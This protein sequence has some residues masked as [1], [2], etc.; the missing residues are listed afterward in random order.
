MQLN[1]DFFVWLIN[2]FGAPGELYGRNFS[3]LAPSEQNNTSSA[4]L[5]LAQLAE[6]AAEEGQKQQASRKLV[7]CCST[8]V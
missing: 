5:D 4:A 7:C 3:E 8:K 2:F 6:K 1:K